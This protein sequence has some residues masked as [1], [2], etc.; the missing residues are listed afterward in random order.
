MGKPGGGRA[1]I[2]NRILS[3]FHL[4]NF[5]VPSE[6]NMKKIYETIASHKF[7]QFDE[8]IRNQSEYLAMAT[9]SLFFLVQKDFLPTPAKP[10]YIFN[11]RDVSKVFQGIYLADSR[12]Y[13]GKENIVKLWVHELLR[14]FSDR[15]NNAKDKE[16]F[17]SYIND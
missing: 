14:V 9:I 3:K 8:D 17:K 15:L 4:I 16:Q 11:M 7:A 10:H 2:S 5:T 12:F 13:E 1:E 6:K